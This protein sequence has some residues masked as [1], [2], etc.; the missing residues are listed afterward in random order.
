MFKTLNHAIKDKT[1]TMLIDSD[2]LAY[3]VTSKLEEAVIGKLI[4]ILDPLS[5]ILPDSILPFPCAIITLLSVNA[6][7]ELCIGTLYSEPDCPATQ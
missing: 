3:K 7:V 6:D 1:K 4:V 5:V 2:L